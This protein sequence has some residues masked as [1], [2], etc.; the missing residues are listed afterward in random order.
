[1]T[2]TLS[3]GQPIDGDISWQNFSSG[4]NYIRKKGKFP[5]FL[6]PFFTSLTLF[7]HL[8]LDKRNLETAEICQRKLVVRVG[9]LGT[10]SISLTHYRRFI[11]TVFRKSMDYKRLNYFSM[12]TEGWSLQ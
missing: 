7:V 10:L 3:L 6:Y 9:E 8:G 11:C 4:S 2:E 5:I 12:L 1:M